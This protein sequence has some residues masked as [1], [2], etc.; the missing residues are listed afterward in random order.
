VVLAFTT[1]GVLASA[2]QNVPSRSSDE[3][4]AQLLSRM[5]Q[6]ADRFRDSLDGALNRSSIDGSREE[7]NIKQF[8]EDFAEA[9]DHLSDHFDRGQVV[10]HDVEDVLRRSV[11]IDEFMRRH[12]LAVRAEN[13][14]LVVRR[15][16]DELAR[17]Y[18]V[19][20]DWSRPRDTAIERPVLYQRLSGTYQLAPSRGDDPRAVVERAIRAVP[21]SQRRDVSERL[22]R[23]LGAPETLAIERVGTSRPMKK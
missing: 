9:T 8:V 4:V 16:L 19:A 3:Q 11:S 10:T 17:V 2:V 20:W 23:R 18:N 13:D 1:I 7:D 12:T 22:L 21:S 5:K 6:H 15:D 14:W